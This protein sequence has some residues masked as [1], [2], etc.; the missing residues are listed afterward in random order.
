MSTPESRIDLV[1]QAGHVVHQALPT[2]PR[3]L[4]LEVAQALHQQGMLRPRTNRALW[5]TQHQRAAL[6]G[7]AR[8]ETSQETARRLAVGRSTV[9]EHRIR[10]YRQLGQS[11]LGPALTVALVA[12]VIRLEDALPPG[13]P[14]FAPTLR[15]TP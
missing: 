11:G 15:E 2:M 8:G 9:K 12:G 4:V 10:A 1:A 7:G 3:A 6:I 14:A 5:L 13:H